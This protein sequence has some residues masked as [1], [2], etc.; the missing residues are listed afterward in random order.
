M[1]GS[2]L[3]ARRIVADYC[4]NALLIASSSGLRWPAVAEA[5]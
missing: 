4:R 1:V 3:V 5:T 2:F